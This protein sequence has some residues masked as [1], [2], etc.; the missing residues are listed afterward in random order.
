MILRWQDES[1][2][3]YGDR[4]IIL[5]AYIIGLSI[6]VH[7][8]NLLCIPAIVL[9]FYYQKYHAISFKGVAAAIVI[10]G[11]L[12]VFILFVYIP[13]IADMGGW[14]ELLFVNVFGLPFHT[15]LI[16]FLALTFLVLVGAI[17]R[18]RKRMLH[19][20]LWCLLMLT[21]GYTT[22]AVILIRANANTPLNE[23]APDNVFTLKSYLNREQ[24]ESAPL[25]YGK[26][27]ASEPEYVPEGDYYRVKTTKGSA[28]Y[29]PDKEMVN[30]K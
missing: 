11:L 2:S 27:Y 24:Y 12:I 29:R 5:I 28:V 19:T 26:T 7:L 9:V 3:V 8:L 1:D 13:G 10:S 14:F 17:Y 15:G 18:F 4:W 30:I 23:N 22:Y 20:S 25:L 21:V 16:V 6:G